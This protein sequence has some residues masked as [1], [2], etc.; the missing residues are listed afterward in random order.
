MGELNAAHA[1]LLHR[2]RHTDTHT[3]TQPLTHMLEPWP[4]KGG[5]GRVKGMDGSQHQ[6]QLIVAGCVC[7]VNC[8]RMTAPADK[9]GPLVDT[10][11]DVHPVQR[12]ST[13]RRR[14]GGPFGELSH[15]CSVTALPE[16]F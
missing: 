13:A 2:H 11:T 6:P 3:N 16:P 7:A 8:F 14:S 12:R 4:H 1:V 10:L 9:T 15:S 5:W